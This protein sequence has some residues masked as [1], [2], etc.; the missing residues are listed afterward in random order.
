MPAD[1]SR[2]IQDYTYLS[3]YKDVAL[4]KMLVTSPT[5]LNVFVGGLS[6]DVTSEI[7]HAAFEAFIL[8]EEDKARL[9]VVMTM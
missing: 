8:K 6:R 5:N 2:S 1:T 9:K 4:W 7:L 3:S